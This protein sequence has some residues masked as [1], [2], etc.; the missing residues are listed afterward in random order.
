M[1]LNEVIGFQLV[2]KNSNLYLYERICEKN[3]R[4]IVNELGDGLNTLMG[5]IQLT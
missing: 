3:Y 4:K 5:W 1:G 2:K